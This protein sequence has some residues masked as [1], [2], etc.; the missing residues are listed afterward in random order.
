ML[1]VLKLL[2]FKVGTPGGPVKYAL[3]RSP[4][5]KDLYLPQ[6]RA[7]RAD[8]D[9]DPYEA[10]LSFTYRGDWTGRYFTML[11]ILIRCIALDVRDELQTAWKE[12][13]RAGGPEKVPQAYA[14]FCKLP[15]AYRDAPQAA[16][17]LRITRTQSAVDVAAACREWSD[18]ARA[19]Y[20][21]AAALAR[22]GK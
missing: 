10:G 8:P 2:D 15:F 19:Q 16:A 14:E 1:L 22:E 7:F 21:K 3:R 17:K 20:L 18:Q 13:I 4:V 11:R 9:Y 6:Y 12:I 5:R